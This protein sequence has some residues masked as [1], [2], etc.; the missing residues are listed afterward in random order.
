MRLSIK[1]WESS[2]KAACYMEI[3]FY[4]SL[5]I[6]SVTANF[7]NDNGKVRSLILRHCSLG[8]QCGPLATVVTVPNSEPSLG[9]S[10][11]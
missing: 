5:E 1:K 7:I 8:L 2:V 3:F 11:V 4:L 9:H 10:A 6:M